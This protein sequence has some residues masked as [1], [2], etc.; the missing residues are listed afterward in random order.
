M[1]KKQKFITV[2]DEILVGSVESH[3]SKKVQ[4]EIFAFSSC[5]D[6]GILEFELR[7][8]KGTHVIGTPIKM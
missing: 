2:L 3:S 6:I 7:H 8:N 1:T 5:D 4:V